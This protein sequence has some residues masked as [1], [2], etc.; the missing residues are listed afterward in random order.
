MDFIHTHI[1]DN[2]SSNNTGFSTLFSPSMQKF[3]VAWDVQLVKWLPVNSKHAKINKLTHSIKLNI[4]PLKLNL[5]ALHICWV[6]FLKFDF[7]F[8]DISQCYQCM[9][10]IHI[11]IQQIE[12]LENTN[13]LKTYCRSQQINTDINAKTYVAVNITVQVIFMLSDNMLFFQNRTLFS[14]KRISCCRK[15]TRPLQIHF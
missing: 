5:P 3:K 6:R 13:R 10:W 7:L 15:K 12:I 14:G 11:H 1:L 2:I 8:N 9:S 4:I